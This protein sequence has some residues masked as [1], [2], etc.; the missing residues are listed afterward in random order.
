MVFAGA[1][2]SRWL[3]LFL[4]AIVVGNF[5]LC[6]ASAQ[7]QINDVHIQPR[8]DLSAPP[9]GGALTAAFDT[10]TKPIHT[11]VDLVLVPV[12]ITDPGDRIVTGLKSGNFQLYEGK[13]P[14][15]IRHF[16]TED[17][18]VSLGI[19][20]DVSGS[21]KGK[22]E[23]AREAALEFLKAANPQDEFF[24][25]GFSDG[26]QVLRDFTSADGDIPAAM[27]FASPKGQTA[28][29]DAIYL[30][31][32]K[33][34]EARYQ[35]RALLIISDGGD[36]H[37]RYTGSEIRNLAK[38]ANVAIYSIG[39]FD[40]YCPTEEELLGPE[41]LATIAAVSG[42]RSYTVDNPNYLPAV[43][44]RV[45]TELRNQYV[46][47]YRPENSAHDGKWHKIKVRLRLP[48]GFPPLH[49]FAKTGYYAPA[50]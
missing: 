22:I 48:R 44:E 31:F 18:P 38:E 17:V 13:H 29:L 50:R 24:L 37:S 12:T 16:S 43:A 33:M 30:G 6:L 41:L 47:A 10:H 25:I 28:L 3:D 35:R 34:R 8:V 26:P 49:I 1:R 40:R 21:M 14:Q 15:A 20:L 7:T 2:L 39:I 36:N 45:G 4:V 5:G 11:E 27:I 19:L 32:A 42:G 46:L 23:R 9:S